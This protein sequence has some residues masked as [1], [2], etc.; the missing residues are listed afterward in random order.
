V[1]PLTPAKVLRTDAVVP[2][3]R[4]SSR[5]SRAAAS[6]ATVVSGDLRSAAEV[7][8]PQLVATTTEPLPVAAEGDLVFW[9]KPSCSFYFIDLLIF[10]SRLPTRVLGM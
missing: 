6:T 9:G 8:E 4:R 3:R 5:A 10:T 2:S 7:S 1:P